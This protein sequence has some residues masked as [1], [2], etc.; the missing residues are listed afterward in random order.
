MIVSFAVIFFGLFFFGL[1]EPEYL[2]SPQLYWYIKV[3]NLKKLY[4]WVEKEWQ[5]YKFG[6]ALKMCGGMFL[7]GRIYDQ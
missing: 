5:I 3:F 4:L 7:W 1:L 6:L 2:L